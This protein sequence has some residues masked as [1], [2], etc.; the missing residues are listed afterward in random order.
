[1]R[2]Q[3]LLSYLF[4]FQNIL[5]LSIISSFFLDIWTKTFSRKRDFP[6]SLV[7]FVKGKIRLS[8]WWKIVFPRVE[9]IFLPKEWM[10]LFPP[11]SLPS[12]LHVKNHFPFQKT[13]ATSLSLPSSSLLP[14]FPF[15]PSHPFHS[16]FPLRLFMHRTKQKKTNLLLYFV[17]GKLFYVENVFHSAKQSLHASTSRFIIERFQYKNIRIWNWSRDTIIM[18][19]QII[20]VCKRK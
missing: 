12:S 14:F 2:D 16:S 3:Q 18:H 5:F 4:L 1:M 13:N 6:I 11:Y 20:R 17:S 8:K 7:W 9:N 19:G 10:P 15:I